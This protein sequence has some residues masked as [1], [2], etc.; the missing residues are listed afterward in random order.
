MSRRRR[1][2]PE[3]KT[4]ISVDVAA[5][6]QLGDTPVPLFDL[7]IDHHDV[8]RIE[9]KRLLLKNDYIA[10]GEIIFELMDE[11]GMEPDKNIACMLYAAISSDSGSFKYYGTSPKTH[12][13]GRAPAGDG[14]RFCKDKPA[15]V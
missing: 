5:A 13:D 10:A 11:F 9:C 1:C 6:G 7:S 14:D 4:Y 12:R 15:F 3:G 2:W 8:N